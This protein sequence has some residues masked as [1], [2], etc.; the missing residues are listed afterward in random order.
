MPRA[1]SVYQM[2][3]SSEKARRRGRAP[4][5]GSLYSP[6]AMVSGSMLAILGAPNSTK[7]GTPFELIIS[8]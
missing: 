6:I 4:S 2:V 8:P 7:Y 1:K 3:S 5:F